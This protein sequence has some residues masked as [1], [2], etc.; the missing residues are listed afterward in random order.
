MRT[1]LA[2]TCAV[3]IQGVVGSA[4]W[5]P[6]GEFVAG[7]FILTQ[8]SLNEAPYRYAGVLRQALDK[9]ELKDPPTESNE[10]NC[11]IR[12]KIAPSGETFY[13]ISRGIILRNCDR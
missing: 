9:A 7:S 1:L 8:K 4:N 6:R 2:L 10:E 13:S 11:D 12:Y 5:R 3:L